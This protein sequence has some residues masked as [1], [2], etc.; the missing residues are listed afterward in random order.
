MS[1]FKNNQIAVIEA[2]MN[3]KLG[4]DFQIK[5]EDIIGEIYNDAEYGDVAVS[6]FG[7]ADSYRVMI[8]TSKA[9]TKIEVFQSTQEH[10]DEKSILKFTITTAGKSCFIAPEAFATSVIGALLRASSVE[11]YYKPFFGLIVNFLKLES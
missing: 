7:F 11:G 6:S 4:I 2:I 1:T 10:V 9:K 3:G 5:E 8:G